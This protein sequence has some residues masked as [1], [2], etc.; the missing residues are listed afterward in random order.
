MIFRWVAVNVKQELHPLF[1][2]NKS[3]VCRKSSIVT[4]LDKSS[5]DVKEPFTTT[6]VP[7]VA[8]NLFLAES[9][10]I[11]TGFAED[12]EVV[13]RIWAIR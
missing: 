11:I 5:V 4:P 7:L 9:S 3:S 2:V 8:T 12:G 6:G 13:K 10:I 1:S